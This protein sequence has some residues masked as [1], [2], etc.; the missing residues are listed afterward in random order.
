VVRAFSWVLFTMLKPKMMTPPISPRLMRPRRSALGV[1]P[2]IR[3]TSFWPISWARVGAATVALV[4]GDGVAL[5]IAIAIEPA[6]GV[7]AWPEQAAKTSVMTRTPATW[8]I[9]GPT[10]AC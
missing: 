8:R 3:T 4:T 7:G 9:S 5:G 1:V 10:D 6:T 2:D